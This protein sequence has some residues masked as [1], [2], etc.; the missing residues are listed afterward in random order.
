MSGQIGTLVRASPKN[1]LKYLL[2]NVGAKASGGRVKQVIGM[3]G[4][5]AL[6]RWM[7]ERGFEFESRTLGREQIFDRIASQ[8]A[9]QR[10]LYLE[11]GVYTG[12]SMRYWSRRLTHPEARLHGFDSFEG[13][14][15][16]SGVWTKGQY[17][18]RGAVPRIDD[19]RVEFFKGWFDQVLP[20]YVLPQ[21]DVLV[22]TLDADL[23]S[24]TIFVLRHLRPWI[25][26]GTYLYFDEMEQVDH[27]PRAF[28]EFIEETGLRFRGVSAHI[29]LMHAAFQCIA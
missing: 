25:K 17:D 11:F 10:V 4:Y 1:W 8:V 3:A 2:L 9:D 7:A 26:P 21:H 5:V 22:V 12:A 15:E 23:Y 16:S 29:S 14:P 13:L 19:P 20:S 18:A 27:E 6:G 24:S 28:G